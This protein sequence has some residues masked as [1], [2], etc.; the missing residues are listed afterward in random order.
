MQRFILQLKMQNLFLML[1]LLIIEQMTHVL[2]H[3]LKIK[4]LVMKEIFYKKNLF[5]IVFTILLVQGIIYGEELIFL[6]SPPAILPNYLQYSYLSGKVDSKEIKKATEFLTTWEF[7][8]KKFFI[9]FYL[10]FYSKITF[11]KD[12]NFGAMGGGGLALGYRLNIK[13]KIQPYIYLGYEHL[14]LT[15]KDPIMENTINDSEFQA[16]KYGLGFDFKLFNWL[17]LGINIDNRV[18]NPGDWKEKYNLRGIGV[19]LI[20]FIPGFD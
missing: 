12:E 14:Q 3:L 4:I 15:I 7:N 6:E 2:Y 5:Q 1:L 16:Y 19:H 20:Y 10:S 17:F 8:H 13:K 11:L 9:K 18:G